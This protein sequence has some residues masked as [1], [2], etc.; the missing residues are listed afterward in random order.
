MNFLEFLG[1]KKMV[2]DTDT[3]NV[4][5]FPKVAVPKLVPPG[6]TP[7]ELEQK[8]LDQT[9]VY[10]VGKTATGRVSLRLGNDQHYTSITMNNDGVRKLVAVL[11]AAMD[12]E[13]ED[14]LDEDSN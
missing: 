2:D 14:D 12:P 9:P 6:P 7:E 4:L 10:Q 1:F 13:N 11:E 3:K 8:R 5:Q